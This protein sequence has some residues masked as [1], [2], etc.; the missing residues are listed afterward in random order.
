MLYGIRKKSRACIAQWKKLF[1]ISGL[2]SGKMVSH[3]KL[4]M[5]RLPPKNVMQHRKKSRVRIAQYVVLQSIIP[6]ETKVY[7]SLKFHH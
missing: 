1:E 2:I 4:L 3:V 7:F 5:E 6:I